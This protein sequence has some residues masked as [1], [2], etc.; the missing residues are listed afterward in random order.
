MINDV[1]YMLVGWM[2][3]DVVY[4][5]IGWMINDVVYMLVG[6]MINDMLVIC[7]LIVFILCMSLLCFTV[8][9]Q[10]ILIVCPLQF[11]Q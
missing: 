7:F 3:N 11:H 1:V 8:S 9:M 2:I 6:W 5:L 10:S 4:M